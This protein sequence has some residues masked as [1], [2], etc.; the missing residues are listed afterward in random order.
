MRVDV[1]QSGEDGAAGQVD[2]VRAVRLGVNPVPG[3]DRA[4]A[5]AVHE[6]PLIGAPRVADQD[7]PR[8][9]EGLFP[10]SGGCGHAHAG[11]QDRE[12]DFPFHETSG[13][14]L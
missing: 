5:I 14:E 6:D 10:R 11:D 1:D 4:N 7:T 9:D 3:T 12:K 2:H 8:P 13:S